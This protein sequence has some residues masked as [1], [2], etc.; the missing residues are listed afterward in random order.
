MEETGRPHEG[1]IEILIDPP[2]QENF[3]KVP[4]ILRAQHKGN[5]PGGPKAFVNNHSQPPRRQGVLLSFILQE[6]HEEVHKGNQEGQ[7]NKL[8]LHSSQLALL[9]LRTVPQGGVKLPLLLRAE[10]REAGALP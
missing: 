5:H 9:H 10:G 8:L 7:L 6:A 1:A 2:I 4:Q 3:E